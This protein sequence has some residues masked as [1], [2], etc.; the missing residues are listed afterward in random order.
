M[1]KILLHVCCGPCT[2]YPLEKL[3]S[4]GWEVMAF[5]YNPNIHPYSEWLR[6][7]EA[8][9]EMAEAKGLRVIIRNDYPLEEFLRNVAFRESQRCTYCYTLRLEATARLAKKSGFDAFTTTLLYSKRQKHELA[10]N[11][12][13]NAAA[14]YKIPFYYE[15]F[16][17]GWKEG[18]RMAQESGIYRQQYCG[19]IFSEKE[20]FYRVSSTGTPRK[21]S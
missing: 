8:L 6:R 16:R 1:K 12:A 5:F 18:Q 2:F 21:A 15:D 14:K 11:I 17:S 9:T 19:C 10:K 4:N 13:E 7:R 3:R 20:R